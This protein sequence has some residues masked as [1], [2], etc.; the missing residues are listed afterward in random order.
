M[1][2]VDQVK[3]FAQ[4]KILVAPHGSGLT[5]MIFFQKA[6]IFDIFGKKYNHF[7]YTLAIKLG[8]EY[9]CLFS[10][11]KY[12]HIFVNCKQSSQLIYKILKES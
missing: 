9:G 6:T 11:A 4:A 1:D 2:W 8:F 10:E 5:N 3:L 12:Q 7:F